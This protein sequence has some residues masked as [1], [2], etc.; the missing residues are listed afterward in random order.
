MRKAV[1]IALAAAFAGAGAFGDWVYE[2]QW[3]SPGAGD[4]QFNSPLG[5][6]RRRRH[7][8]RLRRRW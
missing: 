8:R 1:G 2:G 3:G 6:R 7:G 4:G 5:V